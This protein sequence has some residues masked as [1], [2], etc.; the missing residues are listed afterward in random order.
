LETLYEYVPQTLLP[1]EY[2][3][4]AGTISDLMA[5]TS[6]KL[7]AHRQYFLEDDKFSV[8]ESKRQGKSKSADALFGLEGSFRSLKVE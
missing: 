3:G 6:K 7:L 5:E 2:G 1:T 4:N 8:D